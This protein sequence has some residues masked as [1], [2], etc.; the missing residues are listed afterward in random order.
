[1]TLVTLNS[2]ISDVSSNLAQINA[3]DIQT[4]LNATNITTIYGLVGENTIDITALDTSLNN[5]NV[6]VST[7]T[8][9][10][11]ANNL[12][13]IGN[14][15]NI[16]SNA[17][18]ISQNLTSITNLESDV[19]TNLYSLN[20]TILDVSNN[21]SLI[22]I[23]ISNIA[24]NNNDIQAI[25]DE[26]TSMNTE[27]DGIKDEVLANTVSI[28]A[29]DANISTRTSNIATLNTNLATK[30]ALISSSARLPVHLLGNGD[31]TNANLSSLYNINSATTIQSQLDT[32]TSS[33]NALDTLQDVDLTN[34]PLL[35][36]K[37]AN[38]ETRLDNVDISMNTK[39]ATITDNDLSLSHVANLQT[40][41]DTHTT[42]ITNNLNS[43][44]TN[45]TSIT[46]LLSA[47]TIH[48]SQI[49]A[50]Q[51][52]DTTLQS[53][54]NA[55]NNI[56][57]NS[58]NMLDSTLVFDTSL[59]DTVDNILDIM[60]GNITTLSTGKQNLISA[61]SKLNSLL[62]NRN[63]NLVY[64]D[65]ASSIQGSLTAI[66]ANISLLQGTDVSVIQD[67]EDNFM[68]LD[69]S[70]NELQTSITA[71]YNAIATLSGLQNNDITSFNAIDTSLND[72]YT[73]KQNVI[74]VNNKLDAS[75]INRD[76]NLQY[77]DITNPLQAQLSTLQTNID[78]KQNVIDVN[79]KVLI[80][81]VDL[82]TSSL[83]NVDITTPLQAQ[84]N[85][86]N[87][88]IATLSSTDTAQ[89]TSNSSFTTS[90]NSL[91]TSVSN[92]VNKDTQ[93]DTS[94]N[95]IISDQATVNS[96]LQSNID[97]IVT[98][99]ASSTN[100]KIE[101]VSSGTFVSN[102]LTYTFNEES[103]Y[104]NQL[105]T[106]NVFT[107]DLPI[108]TP[109]N[110]K[111]YVQK[112]VIDALEFKGYVNTLTINNETVEI[113][114]ED[115]DLNINLAPIAGYSLISQELSLTR[116][117]DTWVCMSKVQLFYN[118]LSNKVYDV[119]DPIITMTLVN[120]SAVVDHEINAT[121]TDAGAT[122]TDNIDGDITVN[123]VTDDSALDITTL[124]TYN[125]YYDIS[126]N[127]GN[128]DQK[129][130]VVN[131]VDTTN[132]VITLNDASELTLNQNDTYTEYGA[133]ASD[134]SNETIS[135]TIT[136][137][138]D[139]AVVADYTITYTAQDS[140]GNI[141]STGRLIHVIVNNPYTL[142]WSNS[143]INI[144]TH[145]AIKNKMI[146]DASTQQ[147]LTVTGETNSYLNG[148]YVFECSSWYY[149]GQ[150]YWQSE[151]LATQYPYVS[152]YRDTPNT[153]NSHIYGNIT[154]AGLSNTTMYPYEVSTAP[155]VFIGKTHSGTLMWYSQ[156]DVN[157]N[158]EYV[159]E[160]V[161]YKFPFFVD[162]TQT[163]FNWYASNRAPK[164]LY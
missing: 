133:T 155:Y 158:I 64:C 6:L 159:G 97:N 101:D 131:V 124:G 107:L 139:T 17:Q 41:L 160:Y 59:N 11:S 75:N 60:D 47:D 50:L 58:S 74:D 72:L 96:T 129:I 8:S 83:A 52:Q 104:M 157:T 54:I 73:T 48:E 23:N 162:L 13:I 91:N 126:D 95:N 164:H 116:Y 137:T 4:S 90:I 34:I 102:I 44:A 68:T 42:N 147:L 61:S 110:N 120:G 3:N 86:I 145:A 37:T 135:V 100:Q 30:Q 69:T 33:V 94:L 15:S 108:D 109:T 115:G 80:T 130:R 40:A 28:I 66:N 87:T 7:N 63:D 114:Y 118:S 112:I 134:N 36:T 10:I 12:L 46:A 35:Q 92:L 140:T 55:K 81:N 99:P 122:A 79:N 20:S 149:Q 45:A 5:T 56:I 77:I 154:N 57:I 103:I 127:A 132:P 27:I 121:Y 32:L 143:S 125:I 9:D 19:S 16:T 2:T 105:I 123:I 146:N 78:T 156:T 113:K 82:A 85:T 71:N 93:L 76:D 151:T 26:L 98:P 22:A 39:Q 29:S 38:N 21:A 111:T 128:T 142:K 136:G 148:D 25:N 31:V 144:F 67:I 119:T 161:M 163:Y 51:N 43:S 53:N 117:N 150:Y 65:V 1:M 84:L 138:V 106:N 49:T 89:A 18:G 153:M 152:M 62:L 141:H 88:S 14:T 70:L 24:D